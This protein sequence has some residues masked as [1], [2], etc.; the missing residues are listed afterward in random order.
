M[1]D[2]AKQC[3]TSL[4]MIQLFWTIRCLQNYTLNITQ[5]NCHYPVHTRKRQNIILFIV[6]CECYRDSHS[7]VVENTY[8]KMNIQVQYVKAKD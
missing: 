3:K 6:R 7:T 4:W 5:C 1:A 8:L 2:A